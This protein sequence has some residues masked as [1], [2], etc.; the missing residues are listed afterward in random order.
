MVVEC[1]KLYRYLKKLLPPVKKF[2][3]FNCKAIHIFFSTTISESPLL[4]NKKNC[5]SWPPRKVRIVDFC[6]KNSTFVLSI[7]PGTSFLFIKKLGGNC[8][9]ESK[10]N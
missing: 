1:V 6:L 4:N 10:S 7:G 9:Q 5:F 2:I 3:W 8:S